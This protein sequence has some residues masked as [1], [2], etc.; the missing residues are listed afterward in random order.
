MNDTAIER[1]LYMDSDSEEEISSDDVNGNLPPHQEPS[2]GSEDGGGEEEVEPEDG[3]WQTGSSRN[4]SAALPF[5][6]P[7][8]GLAI[9]N[10]TCSST[11]LELLKLFFTNFLML[12]LV[13]ETNRYCRQYY[14]T[15]G[16]DNPAPQDV[17]I[18]NVPV[19]C[20]DFEDGPQPA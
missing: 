7:T 13:E 11:P 5:I 10:I 12:I 16:D 2:S 15:K 9:P 8:P 17:T 20:L 19:S 1:E 4:V 6:G 14:D 18:R 3:M